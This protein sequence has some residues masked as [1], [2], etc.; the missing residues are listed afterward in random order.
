[1][2]PVHVVVGRTFLEIIETHARR[3]EF[4]D[5]K[6]ISNN[7]RY[8]LCLK[9]KERSYFFLRKTFYTYFI[10]IIIII[11]TIPT[12]IQHWY[13]FY[14]FVTYIILFISVKFNMLIKQVYVS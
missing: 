14:T 6:W 3:P 10:N 2:L 7:H 8:L 13:I 1:M 12:I 11:R 5:T 4:I 9:N